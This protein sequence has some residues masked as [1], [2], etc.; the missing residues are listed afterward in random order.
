MV[1]LT[2]ILILYEWH[3][4]NEI[5]CNT[6]ASKVSAMYKTKHLLVYHIQRSNQ[7]NDLMACNWVN[8]SMLSNSLKTKPHPPIIRQHPAYMK[9]RHRVNAFNASFLVIGFTRL[10]FSLTFGLWLPNGFVA[11]CNRDENSKH[12]SWTA[13]VAEKRRWLTCN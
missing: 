12:Q 2:I 9:C 3:S 10:S 5:S 13:L 11:P 8:N 4:S 6:S 7:N 1:K